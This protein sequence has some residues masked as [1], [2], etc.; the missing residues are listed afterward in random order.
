MWRALCYFKL[1][2]KK[3]I[4]ASFVSV[5]CIAVVIVIASCY[6]IVALIF[7]CR[8]AVASLK[9]MGWGGV[10]TQPRVKSAGGPGACSP[11]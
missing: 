7:C 11:F 1:L 2:I 10:E 5:G 6:F 4:F 3:K 8:R 9:K